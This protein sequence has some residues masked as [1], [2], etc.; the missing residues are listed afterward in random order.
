MYAR[1]CWRLQLLPKPRMPEVSRPT[2]AA[3]GTSPARSIA[4]GR[5]QPSAGSKRSG[6]HSSKSVGGFRSGAANSA[7]AEASGTWRTAKRQRSGTGL[8]AQQSGLQEQQQPA[9]EQAQRQQQQ[10]PNPQLQP[11]DVIEIEPTPGV[12]PPPPLVPPAFEQ[13]QPVLQPPQ[14]HSPLRQYS[15]ADAQAAAAAAAA[16]A[17]RQG[18]FVAGV[19][20]CCPASPGY[21]G[22]LEVDLAASYTFAT[23]PCCRQ[24]QTPTVSASIVGFCK[25]LWICFMS[26]LPMLLQM[27][28]ACGECVS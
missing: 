27:L 7:A 12:Q 9:S 1:D 10:Q 14:Q 16:W 21:S 19:E 26:T 3:A 2:S 22:K 15:S 13:Q 20:R 28:A 23:V 25:L 4:A 6:G 18:Q 11:P 17:V 24:L 8:N 5:Q